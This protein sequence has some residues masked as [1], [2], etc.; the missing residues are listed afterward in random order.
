MTS[1]SSTSD[2]DQLTK[3]ETAF[4]R[5]GR[6]RRP[7][8]K[9][10]MCTNKLLLQLYC[11][12]VRHGRSWNCVLRWMS[13]LYPKYPTKKMQPLI[14]S[15]VRNISRP[16]SSND[17]ID[18]EAFYNEEIDLEYVGP[19]CKDNNLTRSILLDITELSKFVMTKSVVMTNGLLL[20][21]HNFCMK[22]AMTTDYL[23]L[24]VSTLSPHFTTNK[25]RLRN[26]VKTV[27]QK[28][29]KI[30][31]NKRLDSGASF[32]YLKETCDLS[33]PVKREPVPFDDI[34]N[35][36]HTERNTDDISESRVPLQQANIKGNETSKKVKFT[37]TSEQSKLVN[38]T[39]LSTLQDL[40]REKNGMV[41]KLETALTKSQTIIEN[42]ERKVCVLKL[43]VEKRAVSLHN[44][45]KKYH[46]LKSGALYKRLTRKIK[47][48]KTKQ[49]THKHSKHVKV[50]QPVCSE[51]IL[52]RQL[53]NRINGLQKALSNQRRLTK[54]HLLEKRRLKCEINNLKRA[55]EFL[56]AEINDI[57]S[58]TCKTREGQQYTPEMQKCVMEL[59][60]ECE[61]SSKNCSKVIQAV[62]RWLYS[63]TI[64]QSD[65]PCPNT[66]VNIMDKA[67]V[68]SKFQVAETIL[69]SEAFDLHGD[70]TSRDG[71]KILGQQVTLASGNTMSAGFVPVAVEDSA[72][73]LDNAI[74]M[75]Q[76]LCDIYNPKEKEQTYKEL[77]NKMFAT[78]SDRASVNKLYNERIAEHRKD[79]LGTDVDLHFLYCNA[80]FLLGLAN[81]G[82]KQLKIIESDLIKN[83]GHGLGRDNF[84]KFSRFRSSSVSA[85]TRYVQTA[86]DVLGPRGDEKNGCRAQ[87][88]A[89]CVEGLN[90][91]S[92]VTSFR[93]NRFN[94]FFQGAATLYY[95]KDDILKFLHDYKENA[96]LKLQSVYEDCKSPDLQA[97]VKALG[98]VYYKITGPFWQ[99]LNGDT[100]YVDQY[101]FVQHMLAQFKIW[102]TD[103]TEL[104]SKEHDGVFREFSLAKGD[105]YNSLFDNYHDDIT[106]K[107]L[108]E[109]VKCFI[110]VT[111]RQLDDFLPNG[112]YGQEPTP[113]LRE[114][115][116]HCKLTNLLSEN[117]FGDLDFGMYKRRNASLHYHSGL[118][119]IKRNKT[120]SL[121]LS[122]KPIEDQNDLLKLAGSKS[123]QLREKHV[124]AEQIVMMETQ[125]KLEENF[126][127][128][129][130]KGSW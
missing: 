68:L 72:T 52:I 28:V 101:K 1:F 116:R 123:K 109:L 70:G 103:A 124:K 10:T 62:S 64:P 24:L 65:L 95:H 16:K 102:S 105:V 36:I 93:M 78:M 79:V 60:G 21:L 3:L 71:K 87:W 29:D 73:L 117:E 108:E 42:L 48:L 77:L 55:C 13:Q 107:A 20:E 41:K 40:C 90:K 47:Y 96:N 114:K 85:T 92:N 37:S 57:N 25:M 54:L 15:T 113:E 127:K 69:A 100:Q 11:L 12:K 66:V 46:K 30:N 125:Q 98:I 74:A 45:E 31:K 27:K 22:E 82:E 88:E 61:V 56:D 18:S 129:T 58:S 104:L 17:G 67:Q 84:D 44:S 75:M 80:H 63:K 7:D 130:R 128:K 33:D 23:Q 8:L 38:E 76:E 118:Q 120:I 111:E 83:L 94:N 32:S 91:K 5:G 89:F 126:R 2:N 122:S 121:W 119:M 99:M 9:S 34:S 35:S 43:E 6:G 4:L 51:K 50:S 86:C 53:K 81:E 115:M 106:K 97:L 19:H 14:E 112:K 110:V 39:K 26:C 49:C 59:V